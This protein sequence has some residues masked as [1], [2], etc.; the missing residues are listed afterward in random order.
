MPR[1]LLCCVALLAIGILPATA[2]AH[3]AA[4]AAG[5][6]KA[7]KAKRGPRGPKGEAGAPGTAGPKGERGEKGEPGEKGER[8][9]KGDRGEPGPFLEVLPSGRTLRG[10]YALGANVPA[11]GHVYGAISFPVPLAVAPSLNIVKSIPDPDCPGSVA[12][13]KAT[14]GNFCLYVKA[15]ENLETL[16][17]CDPVLYS[18][19]GITRFGA[20]I[21]VRAAAFPGLTS[22]AGTWAVTA[23]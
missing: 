8:G 14:A 16:D 18:C 23:P 4:G 12:D 21:D 3:G 15:T 9:E 6:A 11:S 17:V 1:P 10:V 13:P 2:V 19:P 5:V 7:K 20:M 22:S